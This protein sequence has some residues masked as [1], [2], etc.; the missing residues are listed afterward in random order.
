[1]IKAYIGPL[2]PRVLASLVFEV[3]IGRTYFFTVPRMPPRLP[4]RFAVKKTV[5]GGAFRSHPLRGS[6]LH[7]PSL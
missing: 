6:L 1:M 3:P 4:E 2:D 5:E 7:T